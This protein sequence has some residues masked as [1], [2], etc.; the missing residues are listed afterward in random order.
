[1][2]IDQAI[3]AH[4]ALGAC[5]MYGGRVEWTLRAFPGYAAAWEGWPAEHVSD[6]FWLLFR[7]VA[8]K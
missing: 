8:G 2:T 7:V 1:M 3:A 4:R 6:L 5:E